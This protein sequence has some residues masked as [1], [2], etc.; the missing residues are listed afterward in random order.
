MSIWGREGS[1]CLLSDGR[2]DAPSGSLWGWLCS[3][4]HLSKGRAY[5]LSPSCLPPPSPLPLPLSPSPSTS[6]FPSPSPPCLSSDLCPNYTFLNK[7][8]QSQQP[9]PD[10]V[11]DGPCS[12]AHFCSGGSGPCKPE[13]TPWWTRWRCFLM[14][15]PSPLSQS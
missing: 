4:S 12:Q 8:Q 7:H 14:R 2:E 1:L 11:P 15:A 5:E 9:G 3:L 6:S 13:A 10:K